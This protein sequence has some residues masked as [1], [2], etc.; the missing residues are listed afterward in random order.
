MIMAYVISDSCVNCGSCAPVCPVGAISQGD[1][2]HEIDPNAC[3]EPVQHSAR[4]ARFLRANI[5]KRQE[6]PAVLAAGAFY[7]AVNI[8]CL[9]DPFPNLRS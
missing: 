2:Q 4:S 7:C 5:R 8:F 1:T 3:I 6:A 9:L